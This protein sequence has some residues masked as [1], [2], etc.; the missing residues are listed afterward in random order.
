MGLVMRVSDNITVL[1]HGEQIAHGAPT[2]IRNDPR[3]IAAYL[4]TAV[5]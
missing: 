1:D 3:V 4:G 2:E 5:A